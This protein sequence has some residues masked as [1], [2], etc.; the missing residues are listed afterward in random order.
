MFKKTLSVVLA[1]IMFFSLIVS[2]GERADAATRYPEKPINLIVA[3][4]AGGAADILARI[5]AEVLS[6]HLGQPVVVSNR[7]GGSGTIGAMYI[8]QQPADGYTLGVLVSSMFDTY[9]FIIGTSYTMDDFTFLGNIVT[10]SPILC[11]RSDSPYGTL[12]E[13]LT[14]AKTKKITFGTMPSGIPYLSSMNIFSKAGAIN[15]ITFIPYSK[16]TNEALTACLGG[17]ID[18]CTIWPTDAY[19][20]YRAGNLRPLALLAENRVQVLSEIPSVAE[21][22]YRS[23]LTMTNGIMAPAGLDRE[24]AS[25]LEKAI[26]ETVEDPV[27]IKRVQSTGDADFLN[28]RNGADTRK[29]LEATAELNSALI[30]AFTKKK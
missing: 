30:A 12:E 23:I 2:V 6:T 11:V 14:V 24:V 21:Y 5:F 4:S 27:F 9:P 25:I 16:S 13:L 3:Y 1:A 15:N 10:R 18:V 20:N 19:E 7:E 28:W 17:H 29:D 22:G 8:A 26:K